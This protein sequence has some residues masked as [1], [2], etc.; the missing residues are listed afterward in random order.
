MPQEPKLDAIPPLSVV[1]LISD[2][3]EWSDQ[4]GSVFRIGY[5][6][7]KDGLDCVWLVDDAG[8]YCQTTDQQSIREDFAILNLSAEDDLYGLNRP[9]IGRV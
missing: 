5:Y 3:P 2:N 6:R 9:V 1:R 7:K 8:G 4:K